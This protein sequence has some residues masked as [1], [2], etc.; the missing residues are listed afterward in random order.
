M[1]YNKNIKYISYENMQKLIDM[2]LDFIKMNNMNNLQ[3]ETYN[4]IKKIYIIGVSLYSY[5]FSLFFYKINILIQLT[6]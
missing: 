4:I 5:P 2:I 6:K 1:E 3:K